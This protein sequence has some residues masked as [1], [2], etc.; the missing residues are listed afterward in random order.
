MDKEILKLRL[1]YI[2]LRVVCNTYLTFTLE[3][4]KKSKSSIFTPCKEPSILT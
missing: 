2:I 3:L 4:K 1:N